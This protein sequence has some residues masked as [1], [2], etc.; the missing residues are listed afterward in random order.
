MQGNTASPRRAGHNPV[1]WGGL[2]APCPGPAP[3]GRHSLSKRPR[4]HLGSW[5][6]MPQAGEQGG[7]P[8]PRQSRDV[9][10]GGCPCGEGPGVRCQR[11][12]AGAVWALEHRDLR[13]ETHTVSGCR[14]HGALLVG[15]S[16]PCLGCDPVNHA[17]LSPPGN[18]RP[19]ARVSEISSIP[20]INDPTPVVSNNRNSFSCSSG[21]WDLEPGRAGLHAQQ[22]LQGGGPGAAG[23]WRL[24]VLP[25]LRLRP[26]LPASKVTLPSSLRVCTGTLVAAF[27]AHTDNPGWPHLEMLDSSTSV[28]TFLLRKGRGTGVEGRALDIPLGA[29]SQ[30]LHPPP[31]PYP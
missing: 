6:G 20:I 2:A 16:R 27:E 8:S 7:H 14:C 28:K 15:G 22:R 23:L 24:P 19:H 3:Q 4:T 9:A 21:D 11:L 18:L 26:R 10:L 1:S 5:G 30:P 25:G 12:A 31:H 13:R 29:S 17:L